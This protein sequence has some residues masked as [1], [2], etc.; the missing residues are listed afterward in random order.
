MV[1]MWSVV[2]TVAFAC[3]TAAA[4][5]GVSRRRL[6]AATSGSVTTISKKRNIVK[7]C[8]YFLFLNFL[9]WNLLLFLEFDYKIEENNLLHPSS[10]VKILHDVVKLTLTNLLLLTL[11]SDYTIILPVNQTIQSAAIQNYSSNTLSLFTPSI[12]KHKGN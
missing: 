9:T 10:I 1:D 6:L 12:I 8:F 3:L 7:K 4:W 5:S 11:N 2:T